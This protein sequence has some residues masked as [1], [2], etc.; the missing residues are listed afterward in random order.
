MQ[1]STRTPEKAK[2]GKRPPDPPG[3]AE[4]TDSDDRLFIGSVAKS[5]RV[6]ELLNEA[7][8][9]LTLVELARR[10]G[11]GKSAAQRATHTLRVLGYLSQHPETRAYALS[12]KML[13]FTHTVLAQDRVRAI[14]LPLLES[15]NHVCGETVNLTRLEGNEVVFVARFP[16]RHTV[17]VDLHIGSRLP[18]F[19]TAPGRAMLSRL[20]EEEAKQVIDRSD[21]RPMTEFTVTDPRRLWTLVLEARKRGY[22]L[23]NQ[24]SHIGDVAIGAALVDRG[25]RVVG[26]VNIAAPSPRLS[27]SRLQQRFGA[28]L[29][30]TAAEISRNLGIL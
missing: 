3:D 6:L 8:G 12:S 16:S 21:R 24:E 7:Q 29:M 15:L 2:G 22:A 26:A 4:K 1:Y 11:M 14:A 30:R 20:P 28:D 23:N 13:E 27:I 25:G 17:S 18:A 9:P 19:C 5:F 10:S